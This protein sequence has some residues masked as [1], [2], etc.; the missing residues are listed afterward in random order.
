MKRLFKQSIAALLCLTTFLATGAAQS[1]AL[2][3]DATNLSEPAV[4]V[5]TSES[6]QS[7]FETTKYSAELIAAYKTLCAFFSKNQ[8]AASISLETFAQEYESSFCSSLDEYLQSYY[9]LFTNSSDSRTL[10]PTDYW[11]YN[12]NGCTAMPNYSKYNLLS[13]VQ[14]GDILYE[15]AGSFDYL[16]SHVAIVEGIYFDSYYNT[17]YISLIEVIGVKDSYLIDNIGVCKSVLDDDRFDTNQG[18][19]LRVPSATTAQI[20][21]AISF[22]R[23]A[24]GANYDLDF[25]KEILSTTEHWYGSELIWAAYYNQGINLETSSSGNDERGILPSE[26]W[27]SSKTALRTVT[28]NLGTPTISE[29]RINSETNATIYWNSVTSATSYSVYRSTGYPPTSNVTLLGTTYNSYFVDST[30]SANKYYYYWIVANKS[31]TT[32]NRSPVKAIKT[33]FSYVSYTS[34]RATSNTSIELTWPKIYNAASYDIYR[35]VGSNASFSLIATVTTTSFTQSGLTAG[36]EYFYKIMPKSTEGNIANSSTYTSVTPGQLRKPKIYH[37]YNQDYFH[38]LLKWTSVPDATG[39]RVY[40]STS[41][42]GGYILIDDTTDTYFKVTYPAEGTWY[43]RVVPINAQ[44]E[45][46]WSNSVSYSV[47]SE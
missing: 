47:T 13:I 9:R 11:Y 43:Y 31:G 8:I 3:A 16:D 2:Q 12:T 41:S 24:I 23:N 32:T 1:F 18:H 44:G 39:Y 17:F 40:H 37:V 46:E 29:I 35:S 27:Y 14:P 20:N 15:A 38:I 6:V 22:C 25:G 28:A 42:S 21:G 4:E 7:E 45:G 26:I 34:C 33:S 5:N 36:T 30:L 19:I 10:Y